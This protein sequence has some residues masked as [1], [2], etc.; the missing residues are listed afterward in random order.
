[1]KR[2]LYIIMSIAGL[3]QLSVP[4]VAAR[5][6]ADEPFLKVSKVNVGRYDSEL[7]IA[8]DI[9]PRMINPG[10]DRE[11]IFT[12]V[13][14]SA[15]GADSL[16]LA[17]MS[18][19]GRNRYY[20]HLRNHDLADGAKIVPS[21]SRESLVYRAEVP[22]QPWM[23]RSRVVMREGLCNCCDAPVPVATD[24]IADIDYTVT[25]FIPDYRY[26]ALTGD[27]VI[28]MTAEGR[29]YVNFVVNRT[30]LKPDYMTNPVEIGKIIESIDRVKN[31]PD[32]TITGITIKGYASPEGSFSNNV[33]LAMGRTQT[34]KEYVRSHYNFDPAIMSTAFEPEDWAGLRDWVVSNDIENRDA[35]LAIIDSD[36]EPDPKNEA[37]RRQFP[38][39]YKYLLAEVYPWLRH[40]DYTVRYSI[41][42]YATLDEL[43]AVFTSAPD[44]LR[45]V[46]YQRL[47]AAVEQGSPEWQTIMMKAVEIHPLDE[48]AN[49]NAANIAMSRGDLA[50]AARYVALAGDTPEALYT[51]AVLAARQGDESRAAALLNAASAAGLDIAADELQRLNELRSKTAVTYLIT[52]VPSE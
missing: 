23:E 52:P 29:A 35:I 34:L 47:A 16:E 17:P 5:K 24:P 1:M 49:L 9:T 45:P 3:I 43:R 37:I 31:D 32:A 51:R 26:V 38:A 2:I 48:Q 7:V 39:Q 11:V 36:L 33:R 30:E 14:R 40:S 6:S 44:R 41:R 10:R 18:I 4:A 46:D 21:G 25:P 50:A 20:A 19:A 13:I 22:W 27:S 12:P 28:T 8:I 42:T 15:S